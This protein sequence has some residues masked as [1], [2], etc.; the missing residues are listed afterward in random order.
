MSLDSA[1]TFSAT[2]GSIAI[3]GV[4]AT[5]TGT[6]GTQ[7]SVTIPVSTTNQAYPITIDASEVESLIIYT[8][9]ALVLK[10]NSTGSPDQTLTFAAD[11]PLN[12]VRGMPNACPITTD[13]TTFYFTNASPDDEVVVTGFVNQSL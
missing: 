4:N 1:I 7:I 8:D 6:S 10:T 9:G 2:G 5:A 11:K 13:V 12:W 3:S